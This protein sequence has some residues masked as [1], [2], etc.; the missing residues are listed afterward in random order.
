MNS[1]EFKVILNVFA[2]FLILI[3]YFT[4][5]IYQ[6][7]AIELGKDEVE[8]NIH[9][10]AEIHLIS[11]E[12]VEDSLSNNVEEKQDNHKATSENEYR[13]DEKSDITIESLESMLSRGKNKD[14]GVYATFFM[15]SGEKY[16]VDP[17]F[18]ASIAILETGYGSSN[19][20]SDTNNVGGIRCVSDEEV[21]Y[22][23]NIIGCDSRKNGDFS[24]YASVQDSIEHK[25]FLLKE[26]YVDEGLVTISQVGQKYAPLSDE[27]DVQNLNSNWIR[28]IKFFV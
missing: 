11:K 14:F 10:K 5:T 12:P 22:E 28:S 15:N 26:F 1:K 20:F 17:L 9:K 23:F 19:L 24:V 16:G 25:A 18:L 13:I 4:L 7:K 6:T 2:L 21:I 27:E 3:G 8:T